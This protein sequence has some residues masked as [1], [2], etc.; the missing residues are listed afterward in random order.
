MDH[1]GHRLFE[2]LVVV[3][4]IGADSTG[5]Q[6]TL[7]ACRPW[8]LLC[9]CLTGHSPLSVEAWL[10]A[11]TALWFLDRLSMMLVLHSAPTPF[12][13]PS[14]TSCSFCHPQLRE[15]D[16]RHR[17]KWISGLCCMLVP[18]ETSALGKGQKKSY[19]S[20][21]RGRGDVETMLAWLSDMNV[22]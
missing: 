13:G 19:L 5:A 20:R 6:V 17:A 2:A 21:Y 15:G 22:Q 8:V 9:P 4:S 11:G 3:I 16:V 7:Q 12:S 18:P 10:S 1:F 14:S